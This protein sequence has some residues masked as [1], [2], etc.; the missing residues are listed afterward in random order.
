MQ[1]VVRVTRGDWKLAVPFL[2]LLGGCQAVPGSCSSLSVREYSDAEQLVIVGQI[3]AAPAEL[4]GFA[5]GATKLR[6]QVRACRG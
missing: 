2:L 1:P 3:K 4:Q 5:L 6:G